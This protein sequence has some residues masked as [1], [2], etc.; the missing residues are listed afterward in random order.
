MAVVDGGRTGERWGVG[1]VGGGGGQHKWGYNTVT[2]GGGT[3]MGASWLPLKLWPATEGGK[4]L[5]GH[6]QM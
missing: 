3:R 6:F 4:T 1:E 5:E 2:E